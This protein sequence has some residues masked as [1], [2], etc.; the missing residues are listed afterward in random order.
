MSTELLIRSHSQTVP[1]THVQQP[2]SVNETQI[3][4]LILFC[5]IMPP[6]SKLAEASSSSEQRGSRSIPGTAAIASREEEEEEAETAAPVPP[7]PLEVI[8][9]NRLTVAE[10]R[11]LP[12]FKDH[13]PGEPNKVHPLAVYLRMLL[14]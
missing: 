1:Y 2:E 4:T 13:T 8:E 14:G 6:E 10:I 12:R 9:R 3:T 11:A 7:L 5:R